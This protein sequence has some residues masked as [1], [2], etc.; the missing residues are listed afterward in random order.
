VV[1]GHVVSKATG[2]D[3]E[4]LT[5]SMKMTVPTMGPNTDFKSWKRNFLIFMSLKVAYLIPHLAIHESGVWLDEDAH[6]YAYIL[7]HA[8]NDYERADQAVK[9][10]FAALPDCA[11]AALDIMCE[12]VDGSSFAPSISR[13][14]NFML[15][16]R[17][18][19]SLTQYVHFMRQTFDN[20]NEIIEMIDGYA[21]ILR[22]SVGLLMIRGISNTGH[23]GMAKQ[24]VVNAFDT[25]YLL[26]ADEAMAR[27]LHRAHNM[28]ED[29]HAPGLPA[30]D[31]PAP[32]ISAFVAAGRGSHIGRGHIPRGTHGGLALTNK[33]CACGSSNHIMS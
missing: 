8:T 7:L 21:A 6:T 22:H 16:E 9:C 33:R 31:G 27:I 12:R 5:R 19:H 10:V 4:S 29:V 20:Y 32:P 11:T 30:R 28:D 23:F 18:G 17:P 26:S 24:C 1:T 14:D 15:R 25:S 13:L 2:F 3:K